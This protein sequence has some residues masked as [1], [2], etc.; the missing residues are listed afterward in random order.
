MC[1]GGYTAAE[2]VARH[3]ALALGPRTAPLPAG[4]RP[5][6]SANSCPPLPPIE[7]QKQGFLAFLK[8]A[9]Y[10]GDVNLARKALST[11]TTDPTPGWTDFELNQV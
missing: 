9:V 7:S 11:A 3:S 1:E 4:L 10:Q 6:T 8:W 2:I 5:A